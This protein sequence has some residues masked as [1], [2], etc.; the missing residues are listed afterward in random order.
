MGIL[1]NEAKQSASFPEE[2]HENQ[3]NRCHLS[4]LEIILL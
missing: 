3:D 4:D 1:N 2:F